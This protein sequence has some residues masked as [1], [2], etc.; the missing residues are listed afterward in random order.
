MSMDELLEDEANDGLAQERSSYQVKRN[1][2]KSA[3]LQ[4]QLF[5]LLANEQDRIPMVARRSKAIVKGDPRE[6]MG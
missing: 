4:Q 5:D 3:L 6:F 2:Y 1:L